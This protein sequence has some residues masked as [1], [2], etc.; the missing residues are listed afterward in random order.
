MYGE[1]LVHR[2]LSVMNW[3][4]TAEP[5]GIDRFGQIRRSLAWGFVRFAALG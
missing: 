1:R 2:D 5:H 3:L 4:R